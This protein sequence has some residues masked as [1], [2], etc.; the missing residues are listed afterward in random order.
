[1]TGGFRTRLAH[2]DALPVLSPLCTRIVQFIR[3]ST[4][5]ARPAV[6]GK[7]ARGRAFEHRTCETSIG[8]RSP[9]A[10]GRKQINC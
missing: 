1:M 7:I 4:I 2:E 10:Q 8:H 9:M 3:K 5:Y 6:A